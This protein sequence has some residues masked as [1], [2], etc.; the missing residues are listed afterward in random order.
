METIVG[1][2]ITHNGEVFAGKNHGDI[3]VKVG[4]MGKNVTKG[5]TGFMT[6]MGRFVSR[7]EAARIAYEAG[8]TK[9]R[10]HTLYS[11]HLW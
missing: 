9:G 7:E 5:Q 4:K 6:N 2:A 1:A 3:M 10:V 8:Q 11:Y